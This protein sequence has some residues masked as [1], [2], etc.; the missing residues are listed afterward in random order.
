MHN[1]KRK[2]KSK[3][4]I[5]RAEKC[6]YLFCSRLW[7]LGEQFAKITLSEGRMSRR[8][9]KCRACESACFSLACFPEVGV[10]F[11]SHAR[12]C[13]AANTRMIDPR[14][15]R[16]DRSA[17]VSAGFTETSLPT[18]HV[19]SSHSS[20][21]HLCLPPFELIVQKKEKKTLSFLIF[22]P[23]QILPFHPT[24]DASDVYLKGKCVSTLLPQG[25]RRTSSE[26]R[27][28]EKKKKMKKKEEEERR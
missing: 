28:R 15:R 4:K 19:F 8:C 26:K 27:R 16:N 21:V 22:P 10:C 1:L 25:P 13:R 9:F 6:A 11:V 5:K 12:T 20:A 14:S 17:E 18:V 24:V 7:L 3:K 23:S 2:K